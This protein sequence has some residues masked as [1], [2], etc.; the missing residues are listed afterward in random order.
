[1]PL[2]ENEAE[3]EYAH[4]FRKP[5]I[6][7]GKDCFADGVAVFQS[8]V[9]PE[10]QHGIAKRTHEFVATEIVSAVGVLRAVEFDDELFLPATE[11]GEVRAYR[12]LANEL[13]T[14]ET[15]TFQLLPEQTFSAVFDPTQ[16]PGALCRGRLA[17]TT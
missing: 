12:V 15:A 5:A 17:T 16:C 14:G 7:C 4:V 11:V 9:I 3:V 1:V 13:M 6:Q 8:I 10:A 2:R